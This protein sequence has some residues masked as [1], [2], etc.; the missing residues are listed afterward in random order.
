MLHIFL[1]L[2]YF[3][4]STN[5]KKYVLCNLI[6]ERDQSVANLGPLIN[7][8]SGVPYCS[9]AAID[10]RRGD[11]CLHCQQQYVTINSYTMT[12]RPESILTCTATLYITDQD[13]RKRSTCTVQSVVLVDFSRL[14]LAVI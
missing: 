13:Y 5:L 4:S 6:L 9:V 1:Q 8:I 11:I 10:L 2:N 12:A 3:C 14:P 7:V